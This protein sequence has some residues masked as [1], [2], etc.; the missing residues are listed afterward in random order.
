M[1]DE[2]GLLVWTEIPVVNEVTP[3]EAFT[4]NSLS[5]MREQIRQTCNHPS[6][7]LYGYMN[8]IL[9][10]MLS[11]KRLTE[12]QR[13]QVA[14]DTRALAL[15]LE[16]L[17]KEEAP[18]RN[19]VMAI[20]Y[21]DG[22]NKYEVSTIPDVVGYNLYFG[23]YYEQLEDLTRYLTSEHKRYPDRPII[24]SECG[25]DADLMN[26]SQIPRSWDYSE[27]YQVVLHHSYLKQFARMP[28][29]RRI[30]PM[31]FRRL[32]GRS[33]SRRYPLDQ[34]ERARHLRP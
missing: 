17:T 22:Y 20:H 31:E 33:P 28:V 13:Q 23:W 14:D 9:I 30:R 6:V 26:H 25:A 8:E 7:I 11:N 18:D 5:M 19:T 34:S 29:P 21:E 15:K 10:R 32:R 27:E 12:Q 1:C 4:R 3:S 2:L 24:V 16:A